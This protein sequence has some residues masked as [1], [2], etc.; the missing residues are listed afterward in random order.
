[1]YILLEMAGL[2]PVR[3]PLPL[4]APVAVGKLAGVDCQIEAVEADL[5]V[6]LVEET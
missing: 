6:P 1:M 2:V 5:A 4:P 3:R